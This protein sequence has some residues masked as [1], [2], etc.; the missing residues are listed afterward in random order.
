M[1]YAGR[2]RFGGDL[3]AQYDATGWFHTHF[4]GK[5]WWLV[6]PDGYRF[7][8][9]GLDC[10]I[11]DDAGYVDDIEE[12]LTDIPQGEEYAKAFEMTEKNDRFA[13]SYI[14]YNIVNLVCVF[15]A[16]WKQAWMEITKARMIKWQFNTIGNW[17]D[18][19]FIRFARLPYVWPLEGYPTTKVK[20]FRDFPDVF[21]AEYAKNAEAFSRQL[22]A[23]R[24]DPCMIGYFMRNEPEWAFVQGLIIADKVLENPADTCCKREMLRFIRE[25]YGTID[26]LN[27]AWHCA[28]SFLS[29]QARWG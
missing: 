19:E 28:Y 24:D 5:R 2:S 1:T 21:S 22:E 9:T 23:F 25:K 3:N 4:D 11:P 10:C 29:C 13:G 8:S 15:G 16:E 17:S 12:L 14:N 18:P 27:A 6:D 26:A 7:V 20:V